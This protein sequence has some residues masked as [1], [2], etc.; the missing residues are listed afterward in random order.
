MYHGNDLKIAALQMN[1][2]WGA[3]NANLTQAED[4]ISLLPSGTD[5]VVLPEMFTTG[6]ILDRAEALSVAETDQGT[7]MARVAAWSHTFNTAICGSFIAREADRLY[8]R[9]F[10]I[11]PSGD[12]T[13]YD[14]RHLFIPSGE[15]STYTSGTTRM[16]VIRYRGWNIAMAICYDLRFPVWLRSDHGN[17]DLLL[18]MANW[19]D[20]R[21]FAWDILLA[22]RA[23]ENQAYVAGCN[24]S[25]IDDYGVYSGHSAVIDPKGHQIGIKPVPNIVTATLSKTE[26]TEFRRKFPVYLHGDNY[27]IG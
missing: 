11:D 16:P 18:V 27:T 7:T 25:G 8:N 2:E 15:H 12:C 20:S 4:M 21:I 3:V 22:A 19:P 1:I 26:L 14:K 9:A 24:R 10:F 5:V 6:F 17:Y 13:F 23:I